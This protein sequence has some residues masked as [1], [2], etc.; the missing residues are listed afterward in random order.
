M[1]KFGTLDQVE[2]KENNPFETVAR[3][4]EELAR[5]TRQLKQWK[6]ESSRQEITL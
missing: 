3:S 4:K 1:F 5:N 2:L 6:S